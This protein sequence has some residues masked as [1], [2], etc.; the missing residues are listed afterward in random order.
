MIAQ[1]L[2]AAGAVLCV[3][4]TYWS[5]GFIVLVQINYVLAPRVLFLDRF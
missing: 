1:A 2:Y 3:F 5:L 4:S